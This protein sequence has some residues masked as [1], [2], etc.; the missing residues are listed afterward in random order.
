[1]S[2]L[3]NGAFWGCATFSGCLASVGLAWCAGLA[4]A[5][6]T[7]ASPTTVPDAGQPTV[8]DLGFGDGDSSPTPEPPATDTGHR[9]SSYELFLVLTTP[10][11]SRAHI[12]AVTGSKTLRCQTQ[13]PDQPSFESPCL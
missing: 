10:A 8:K 4:G 1:M 6:P 12:Q 13:Q 3:A 11:S 5:G 7:T 2:G 9:Q